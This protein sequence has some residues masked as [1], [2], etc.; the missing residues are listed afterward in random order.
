MFKSVLELLLMSCVFIFRPI[1]AVISRP[2]VSVFT[3][4]VQFTVSEPFRAGNMSSHLY[5][6]RHSFSITQ[7][8]SKQLSDKHENSRIKYE[9]LT[10]ETYYRLNYRDTANCAV[11]EQ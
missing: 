10:M 6:Y 7:I 1:M 5:F 4:Q 8:V 2:V 11:R 9:N 3:I